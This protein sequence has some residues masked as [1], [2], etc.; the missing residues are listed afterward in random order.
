MKESI[1][2]EKSELFADRI[3]KLYTYLGKKKELVMSKSK[4]V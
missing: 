1:L 3:V 2:K 4:I